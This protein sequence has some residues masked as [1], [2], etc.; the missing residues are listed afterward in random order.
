ML[1]WFF[2]DLTILNFEYHF[3][4]KKDNNDYKGRIGKINKILGLY[5]I[6]FIL[7]I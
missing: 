1:Y 7:Y 2:G 5:V 4:R 6:N 3:R